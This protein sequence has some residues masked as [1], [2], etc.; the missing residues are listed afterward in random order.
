MIG[1]M[2]VVLEKDEGKGK[3]EGRV[4]AGRACRQD[5]HGD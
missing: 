2:L 3:E 1:M 5:G 4:S